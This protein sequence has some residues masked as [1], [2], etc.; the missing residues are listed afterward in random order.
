MKLFIKL[1]YSAKSRQRTD[2]PTASNE[3]IAQKNK[4][5]FPTYTEDM[6]SLLNENLNSYTR[7]ESNPFSIIRYLS[8]KETSLETT[9]A[10]LLLDKSVTTRYRS[11]LSTHSN[12]FLSTTSSIKSGCCGIKCF[13]FLKKLCCKPR[14]KNV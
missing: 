6:K 3:L 8:E 4:C 10:D 9:D 2:S 12:A 5:T 14:T 11:T 13:N 7:Q 1:F